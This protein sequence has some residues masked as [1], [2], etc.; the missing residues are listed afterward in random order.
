M[1]GVPLGRELANPG[2][3]RNFLR[4]H[5]APGVWETHLTMVDLPGPP[6]TSSE[7]FPGKAGPPTPPVPAQ[8]SLKKKRRLLI[9]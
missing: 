1:G 5:G 4:I 3:R 2:A 6:V 7:G 9:I 8:F